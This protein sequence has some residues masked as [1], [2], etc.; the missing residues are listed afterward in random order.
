MNKLN[1]N[2]LNTQLE[3]KFQ[4]LIKSKDYHIVG[5]NLNLTFEEFKKW[6]R[7]I[8]LII[9]EYYD[10]QNLEGLECI[11]DHNLH[12]VLIRKDGILELSKINCP[13][14]SKKYLSKNWQTKIIFNDL[15]LKAFD[16]KFINITN[17]TKNSTIKSIINSY[18]SIV[19]NKNNTVN[20]IFLTSS[21]PLIPE[22]IFASLATLFAKNNQSVG[23]VYSRS[24]YQQCKKQWDSFLSE[25]NVIEKYQN[26]DVLF[27]L[28][29]AQESADEKFYLNVFLPIIKHR[30]MYDKTTFFHSNGKVDELKKYF[31]LNKKIPKNFIDVFIELIKKA[32][33]NNSAVIVNQ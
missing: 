10:C 19:E 17:Q 23:I 11:N 5:D 1:L 15:G 29:L 4:D 28:D 20:G 25:A 30:L 6:Y 3:K 26:V 8:D 31:L 21:L 12:T 22:R 32:T 16:D 13:K 7:W 27:I 14:Q 18:K 9:K 2:S 24:I 33:N